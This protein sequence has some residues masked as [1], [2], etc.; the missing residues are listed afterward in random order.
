MNNYRHSSEHKSGISRREATCRVL[1][2]AAGV[3]L[4]GHAGL[5]AMAA[6][7]P[8]AVKKKAK[9]KAVIQ[10]WLWGGP[11]HLD[12]FDPKPEAGYDYCGPLIRPI[13]TNVPGIRIGELLPMLAKQADKY[14]IIR[15]MTHGINAH[16]T[17]A[18]MV[19]TGRLPGDRQVYPGVGAVVSLFRGY[20]AGYKGL[21]PPYIVMTELQGR[22]SE[23]GF[24][25]LR[26]KPFATGGDPAQ[27]RFVVEG[28]VA[29]GISD[30]RQ[31]QRRELLAS[32][33]T[34]AQAMPGAR[35]A[36]L[37]RSR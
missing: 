20:D 19:Q 21:V 23:A 26:Y 8:L 6:S 35:L 34:L 7:S 30:Q 2:S 32:L 16:E 36:E 3:L 1:G 14:S 29:P 11:S 9:A 12:T 13:A 5:A 18:Y 15:S 25:G 31:H 4:F 28:V 27:P 22:F 17:A 37:A 10:V 33:N 24:L